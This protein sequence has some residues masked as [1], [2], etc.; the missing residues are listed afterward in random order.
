MNTLFCQMNPAKQ[1]WEASFQNVG[2]SHTTLCQITSD[3]VLNISGKKSNLIASVVKE[4][5]YE[6]T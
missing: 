5:A 1:K 6:T 2:Q 4:T 3:K